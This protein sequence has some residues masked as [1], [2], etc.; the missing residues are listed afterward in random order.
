MKQ[1]SIEIEFSAI[2]WIGRH[3]EKR[4]HVCLLFIFFF[5]QNQS[6]KKFPRNMPYLVHDDNDIERERERNVNWVCALHCI[7]KQCDTD[8]LLFNYNNNNYSCGGT[9]SQRWW[10]VDPWHGNGSH[11]VTYSFMNIVCL[12]FYGMSKCN[13]NDERAVCVLCAQVYKMGT[14][15]SICNVFWLKMILTTCCF[16][17]VKLNH[18]LMRR[19]FG[20]SFIPLL[21]LFFAFQQ[22]QKKKQ[23]HYKHL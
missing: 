15:D 10:N 8:S 14:F 1:L 18:G 22:W 11:N 23:I 5:N 19:T 20:F 7:L 6:S 21:P 4:W 3:R 9:S 12:Q 16:S 13:V 2:E 17:Y